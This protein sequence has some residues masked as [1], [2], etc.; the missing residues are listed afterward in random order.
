M[1]SRLEWVPPPRPP[2]RSVGLTECI[3]FRV[4]LVCGT[5]LLSTG[6]VPFLA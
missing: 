2:E 4:T 5:I 1:L 6:L 3:L